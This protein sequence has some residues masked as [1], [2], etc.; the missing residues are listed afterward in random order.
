MEKDNSNI[1][2]ELSMLEIMYKILDK[3]KVQYI[4]KMVILL[5]VDK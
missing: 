5:F 2:Q 1:K 4:Q 3:D